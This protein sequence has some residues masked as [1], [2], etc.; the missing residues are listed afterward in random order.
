MESKR[1]DEISEMPLSSTEPESR[2]VGMKKGSEG[3][4]ENLLENLSEDVV[5]NLLESSSG[6]AELAVQQSAET[7]GNENTVNEWQEISMVIILLL[8]VLGQENRKG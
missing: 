2:T 8:P 5:E 7:E 4:M 6:D 3:V 1:Q